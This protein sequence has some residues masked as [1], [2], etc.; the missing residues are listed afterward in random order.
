MLADLHL[1]EDAR[2]DEGGLKREIGAQPE[3]L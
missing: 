1:V 3:L 2:M